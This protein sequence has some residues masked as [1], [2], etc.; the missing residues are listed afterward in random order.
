MTRWFTR[1][2]RTVAGIVV[3]AGVL[4]TPTIAAAEYGFDFQRPVT[5]IAH[6]QLW[7]HHLIFY[8]CVVIFVGVFGVMFYALAVHRKSRG[9]K[10]ATFHESTR[11]E[12]AWT[13]IPFFILVGM[14]YPS[15]TTLL[16]MDDVTNSDLTVK[17]TGHQ[18]KWEYEYP[19]QNV[20]FLS[21]LSTPQAQIHNEAK[22]DP[23]YLLE[24]DKPLVLPVGKKVRLLVTGADVIHSWWVPQLGVKKDAIPGF[25]NETWTRIDEPGTY[26]G[27]CAELCGKY[28][29]F[30]PIVVQA[31]SEEEFKTW[32][33]E[34][35]KMKVAAAAAAER[36]WSKDELIKHGKEVYNKI[37]AACHQP[38]G[39]GVP[40]T[41]PALAGSKIVTG[42]VDGHLHLVMNG[43]PGTAMQAFASQLNDVDLAAVVSYERN[44][45]GNNT[46]DVVQP[47]QVK[48]ARK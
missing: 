3:A 44:A 37:C 11:I 43:K 2:A 4:L 25:I 26:R 15:T 40:G 22:K 32:I 5:E 14:A 38:N 6:D 19:D 36:T 10:A 18:W 8:V 29:G 17:I 21:A 1:T 24:V 46:G 48:A 20:R 47:S 41:F 30:M 12:I 33:G 31:V 13:I 9:H 16:R 35:Q 42:P 45:F 27:Q 23:H 39:K 34:Q 28:H 7:L